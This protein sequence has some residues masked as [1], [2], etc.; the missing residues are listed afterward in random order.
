MAAALDDHVESAL[1]TLRNIAETGGYI[2]KDLKED[3]QN[4]VSTLEE[5][6]T[7]MKKAL[8][9]EISKN[10]D[11]TN[12]GSEVNREQETIPIEER[13]GCVA[14]QVAPSSVITQETATG[15]THDVT[16]NGTVRNSN[17]QTPDYKMIQE[18][19]T[20]N[21]TQTV[22]QMM[23][24]LTSNLQSLIKEEIKNTQKEEAKPQ[25]KRTPTKPNTDHNTGNENQ[26]PPTSEV[27]QEQESDIN[28][29][30]WRQVTS[31]RGRRPA[32]QLPVVTG[33]G[34]RDDDIQAADKMAWLFV[35]RLKLH[36]TTDAVKTYIAKKG[37]TESF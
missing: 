21:I 37:I 23:E 36:T 25:Q 28:E 5:Y 31:G 17:N 33:T 12:Q 15:S 4:A 10:K 22:R 11:V 24:T 8:C 2:K 30:Q 13:D 1:Q 29:G 20:N 14:R 9:I 35:G 19:I 26:L 6:I 18:T 7:E 32:R 3:I 34:P 27:A 16:S